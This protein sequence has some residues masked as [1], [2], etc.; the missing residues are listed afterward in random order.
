MINGVVRVTSRQKP[1]HRYMTALLCLAFV[2]SAGVRNLTSDPIAPNEYMTISRSFE[3]HTVPLHPLDTL[4]RVSTRSQQHGPA[5]FVAVSVWA[6]LTGNDVATLRLLSL[7]FGLLTVAAVF[8]LATTIGNYELAQFATILASCTSLFVF[9][10][11]EVRMYSLLPFCSA[12][13]VWSYYANLAGPHHKARIKA[14]S[15]FGSTAS[16][17]YVHY[18]GIMILAAVT[19]YHAVFAP[20]NMRWMRISF[21]MMA[22]GLLFLPWLPIAIAGTNTGYIL[23]DSRLNLPQTLWT[24]MD[25]YTNGFS[26]VGMVCVGLIVWRRKYLTS[27]QRYL[28]HLAVFAIG[29]ALIANEI[30]PIFLARRMRYSLVFLPLF[31]ISFALALWLIPIGTKWRAGMQAALA[32][33]AVLSFVWFTG[34]QRMYIY[35][36]GARWRFLATPHFQEIL[37]LPSFLP[38]QNVPVV[39]L[40]PSTELTNFTTTFYSKHLKPAPLIHIYHDEF[41]TPIVQSVAENVADLN[42]FVTK[43]ASFWLLYNPREMGRQP[44]THVFQWARN[45]YRS[46]GRNVDKADVIVERFVRD[47]D[48]C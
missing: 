35:T 40:H 16:I 25:V 42:A 41:D 44:M 4:N 29:T 20:K 15:L 1:R 22:G 23:T 12:W 45:F 46:C 26:F 5:Y 2:F 27:S 28:L 30:T 8:R 17:L 6:T 47:S 43:Y 13:V 11:H 21:V 19:L 39:S 32:I 38:E 7:F 10:S 24:L 33:S 18:F 3:N 37:Y 9:F 36:E 14:L 48:P 31:S 34:S